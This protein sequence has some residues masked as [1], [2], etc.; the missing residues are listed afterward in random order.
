MSITPTVEQQNIANRIATHNIVV[1][2]VAGSGK[3]TTILHIAETYPESRILALTY[4]AKLKLETQEKVKARGLTNIEVHSF[5]ACALRYYKRVRGVFT[6]EHFEEM[7]E[8]NLLTP[9]CEINFDI[10][11][12]D[13]A[14]D[15]TLL[16]YKL[17]CQLIKDCVCMPKLCI[18]GDVNQCIFKFNNSDSRF[19]SMAQDVF[20]FG[21]YSAEPL[22]WDT[23]LQLSRSFRL[24]EPMTNF[25]NMNML[26]YNRLVP[27]NGAPVGKPA[28]VVAKPAVGRAV[29]GMPAAIK[30]A[31]PAAQPAAQPIDAPVDYLICN[32]YNASNEVKCA[33]SLVVRKICEYLKTYQPN[34]VF[35]L[36]PS[37][38]S[39]KTPLKSVENALQ[40]LNNAG[41]I[42]VNIYVP[43]NDEEKLDSEV[44]ANKLVISSF[45]QSKGLERDC[46]VVFG[47]DAAYFNYY[48]SAYPQDV[49]SN[50]LYVAT[51]RA[52]KQLCVVHHSGNAVLP[53]L[54]MNVKSG[55]N[56]IA[57]KPRH[58]SK[59]KS[60]NKF[61]S[62]VSGDI[63]VTDL[64]RNLPATVLRSAMAHVKYTIVQD[65]SD[66]IDIPHKIACKRSGVELVGEITGTAIPAYYEWKTS[67]KMKILECE[68]NVGYDKI[69]AKA[70]VAKAAE[71]K[72]V[73]KAAEAK[74][75]KPEI[76]LRIAAGWCAYASGYV[77]KFRQIN[78]H[79]DWNWLTAENLD[80]CVSR[81]KPVNARFEVRFVRPVEIKYRL[82]T[83]F[84]DC[85]D[86][87]GAAWEFKCCAELNHAHVLQCV[88]Y[89]YLSGVKKYYLHNLIDDQ[90][91]QIDAADCDVA[92]V[93]HTILVHKSAGDDVGDAE[94]LESVRAAREAIFT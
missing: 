58:L 73:A 91:I 49:C 6:D 87:S 35:L 65:K 27:K 84:I 43:I 24:T 41:K 29:V 36:A 81:I 64:L 7:F 74:T 42:N 83:G 47:F 50:E 31:Q 12:V 45:H 8:D 48:A 80:A 46:V 18:I 53:F 28:A 13:E 5:H 40:N 93:L 54:K 37:V 76:L 33:T 61:V 44:I 75:V 4:S 21:A 52:R 78:E 20:D 89:M 72:A 38:R 67:G 92:A 77:S 2:S 59:L 94:F 85:I 60:T 9:R 30:N 79:G 55:V 15:L 1:D 34:Q 10:I 71:A 57:E 26:G 11:I 56:I 90:I 51:T 68:Y 23:T 16:Y 66:I 82:L 62:K 32:V 19:I 63:S 39:G 22:D 3:T 17:I 88:L 70:A 86:G 14:Q 69:I 25:I